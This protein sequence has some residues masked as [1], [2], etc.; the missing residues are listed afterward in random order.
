MS[1]L[2]SLAR[3]AR[4][5]RPKDVPVDVLR[6]A[7]VQNLAFAG[8]SR[9]A[10]ATPAGA[11]VGGPLAERHAGLAAL[12]GYDDYLLAGRTSLGAVP[13]GWAGADGHTVDE[14]ALA[15]VIGNEIGGRIGL[16]LLLGA[17]H[18]RIDTFVPA[19]AAAATAAWLADRDDEGIAR[20]ISVA[21]EH[22]ERLTPEQAA[23]APADVGIKPVRA[24]TQ[25]VAQ[26]AAGRTDLLD[27]GSSFYTELCLEPLLGAYAGLGSVWLTRTLVV[28]PYA[29]SPWGGVAV[30]G[31]SEILR[32]HIKAADKRLRAEQVEKIE[33]R[34]SLFP[35][36]MDQA[37]G[38]VDERSPIAV[39]TSIKRAIGVLVARHD[40]RPAD[41]TTDAIHEK[42]TEIQHVAERVEI[43]HDWALSVNSVESL[44]RSLGPILAGLSPIQLRQ[45]RTK[46]K[47]TGGWPRWHRQD[48][49]PIVR[50]RPDRVLRNLQG[51]RGDLGGVDIDT[52]RWSLPVE[53]KLYTT[54]GGWWPERRSLPQGT[55]AGGDI[56]AV[57]LSKH[58]GS[59]ALLDVDGASSAAA[60]VKELLA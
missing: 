45:V 43:V 33:V 55:V 30:E 15:T 26:G 2:L 41:L 27:E 28:K 54:R 50:S 14:L 16:A 19:A 23:A 12:Y 18:T 51:E 22:G 17:R 48:L 20:A 34:T 57:A 42:S 10:A 6:L 3:W 11:A 40:L 58:G 35:W 8:S 59:P 31:V 44:T 32:R 37:A 24:A 46:L 1:H 52:F 49:W 29:V 25:A 9:A 47:D 53:V 7:R 60:W 38:S 5:L 56:E 13:A 36:G 21:L 4:S 39:A